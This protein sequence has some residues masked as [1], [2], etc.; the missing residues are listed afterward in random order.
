M[1]KIKKTIT[2]KKN[3]D[4]KFNI[5][6]ISL[7]IV[8]FL[9]L[10]LLLSWLKVSLYS[11]KD[12]VA[13]EVVNNYTN[14]S[15]I[16]TIDPLVSEKNLIAEDLVSPID[17]GLDPSLGSEEADVTIFYFSDYACSYCFEQGEIIKKIY[18]KF[19]QDVRIIWKDY[20]DL[21]SVKTFSYQAA[22]AARCANNQGKFW[23][24]NELL[25]QKQA[26]FSELKGQLFLNLA[27]QVKLDVTTFNNCLTSSAVNNDIIENVSEAESLGI[28]GIPYIYIN[29]QGVLGSISE[30]ELEDMV[31]T[32]LAK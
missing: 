19:K 11:A 1:E 17:T 25:Y 32:E 22:K 4:K 9:V 26:S 18:D 3:N 5:I 6:L 31:E 27:D 10:I 21:S 13:T 28:V 29:D 24:Y 20:P 8:L 7:S 2:K 16:E 15:T 23:D 14:S 12:K 30:E